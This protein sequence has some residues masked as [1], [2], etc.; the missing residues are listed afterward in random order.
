[1]NTCVK[2]R[3]QRT[4][5]YLLLDATNKVI[6]GATQAQAQIF[7]KVPAGAGFKFKS[8][9]GSYLR[10][11]NNDLTLD[12]TDANALAFTEYDCSSAGLYPG[13]KGYASP[14]GTAPHWKA[15]TTNGAIKSG[16]GG[17]GASCVAGDAT[18]WER[19]YPE[20]VTCGSSGPVCGDGTCNGTE[21]CSTCSAD[22][23]SCSST[24]CFK[25][26]SQ[27]TNNYLVLD[28]ANK[29]VPG[30]TQAQAQVFE[31]T[32]SGSGFTFRG[33][34]G[35]Y[36]RLVGNDLTVDATS[37]GAVVFTEYDCSSAGVY[38]N[39]KG[40]SSPTGA[41]PHWKATTTNGPIQSGDGGNGASCVAGDATAWE[42]FYLESTT[43][44]STGPVCGDGSCNGTETCS[45]CSADCGT[46]SSGSCF[47]IRSQRT[48]NYLVLDATSKVVPGGTL[49]QAQIF[50]K[51]ASGSGFKFKGSSGNYL[52]VVNNDLTV[53]TTS[54]S[55]VVFNEQ[56]CSSGG[57]YPGGKGYSSPTGAAP[58]WKATTTNGAIKSGDGGN[59]ASCAAGSG[60]SWERFYLESATCSGTGPVCG[61]ASCNGS[62]TCGSCPG[63]C[64]TCSATPA[65][66][67]LTHVSNSGGW[68]SVAGLTDGNLTDKVS[69][70]TT[71]NCVTYNLGGTFTVTSARLLEDNAGAW[72][73]DTWKVQVD[74]GAGF[75]DAF[76]YT[77]TP[78]A[79]PSWN[80]VDF[81][82]VSG[83]TRVNVCV[84][85]TGAPVELAE[86]EA[87]GYAA[88]GAVCGD[89]SCSGSETCSTCPWDC[90]TCASSQ[91]GLDSRPSNTAC[92]A[93]DGSVSPPFLLSDSPCIASV[94]NPPVYASGVIPYSINEPFWSD[95]AVKTRF[96]ALP[97]GSTFNVKSDG[98]FEMP[99]GA[100]TIKTFQWQGQYFETRF[101]VRFSTGSYGAW[102]YLWNDT[103]D[104]AFLV[105]SIDGDS[106]TL[107][108]GHVWN[109]PTESQCFQ[110]HTSA[111]GFGL[112]LE[113]RQINMSQVYA[114]TGRNSNQF[115]TLNGIGML[116]GNLTSLPP[117]PA[118][119]QTA[120]SLQMRADAY[121]HVN[122][123]NCHRPGG[124]GYG[125]GD[126]RFDT[127]LASK[128]ICNQQSILSAYPGL[129]LIEP[130][131][132]D[133]SVV[134]LRM[135]Q[136]TQNYMPPIAS[137]LADAEGASLLQQWIDGLSGCP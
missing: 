35:S 39:G 62:E 5:N 124:T 40:Y 115:D 98:D 89:R 48:N 122:C 53:D 7:E 121:L 22:C 109:Y 112:G 85:N 23:G 114:A 81:A 41:A 44:G 100:V 58:Y 83:V 67:T 90:D 136:R 36:A 73:T 130:G 95:S 31:K 2:I 65:K 32:A 110:C 71:P 56:D 106:K 111:A 79:M 128:N 59:G 20:T 131:V 104:E 78:N 34:S 52:R 45:T 49:A 16:D 17:N 12:T 64:G 3:S 91:L 57:L 127:L 116:S 27:R 10:V 13:G 137:K 75:V 33:S 120:A 9:A 11:V 125:T 117:L 15:T 132:H 66:L 74:T 87:W 47:T 129:D 37:S 93:G 21:T 97:N 135:S 76:A 96:F 126:Y 54:S 99:P 51:V 102:T 26:R 92:V 24:G 70:A 77:S 63:D 82:D 42:R 84:E 4:N 19:F 6:P 8:S 29:V 119:A 88:A 134:W 86:I 105:D 94:A 30:G 55:A 108:G 14:T 113:T 101:F 61:D 25:I 118:H 72:H 28:A 1:C 38:P 43:C 60:T 46:C 133:Q 123:S 68:T 69:T 18:S 80:T 50:E 107:P 103:Q